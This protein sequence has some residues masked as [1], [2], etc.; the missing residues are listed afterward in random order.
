MKYVPITK[1]HYQLNMRILIDSKNIPEADLLADGSKLD[2]N[3]AG[4]L[5]VCEHG[6]KSSACAARLRKEGKEKV[7][8][9]KGGVMAWRQENLPVVSDKQAD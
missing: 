4:T 3:K 6:N 8:S 7:F 1:H 9:I 5:L 2:K